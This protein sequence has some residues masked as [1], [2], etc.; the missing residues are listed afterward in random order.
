MQYKKIEETRTYFLEKYGYPTEKMIGKMVY[1]TMNQDF[2]CFNRLIAALTS[3]IE[4]TKIE[5]AE[6]SV[7]A[8]CEFAKN[9]DPNNMDVIAEKL[10][11]LAKEFESG[12]NFSRNR[13][14][15][16][17]EEL[18]EDSLN[19]NFNYDKVMNYF[20]AHLSVKPISYKIKTSRRRVD[21][22]GDSYW[23]RNKG[24]EDNNF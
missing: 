16:M 9:I 15:K 5:D 6:I 3:C 22:L 17:M 1:K 20:V 14:I 12:V 13:F 23:R 24:L 7:N 2:N 8:I 21:N 4:L 19:P 18:K 10:E 11:R